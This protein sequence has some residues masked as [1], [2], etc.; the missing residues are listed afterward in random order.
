MTLSY[1]ESAFRLKQIVISSPCPLLKNG[2]RFTGGGSI[3]ALSPR[4]DKEEK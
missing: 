3:A 2:A 1:T 4:L